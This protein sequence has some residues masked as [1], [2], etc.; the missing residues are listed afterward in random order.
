[1]LAG[2]FFHFFYAAHNFH[3]LNL[4]TFMICLFILFYGQIVYEKRTYTNRINV[5]LI[6]VNKI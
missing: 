1:M 3:F 2:I 6:T 5:S 4:G